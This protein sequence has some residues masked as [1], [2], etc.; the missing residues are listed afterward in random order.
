M[1]QEPPIENL[2]EAI[3]RSMI[4]HGDSRFFDENP[5]DSEH[6]AM[7]AAHP[8][9]GYLVSNAEEVIRVLAALAI[10]EGIIGESLK[11]GVVKKIPLAELLSEEVI[12]SLVDTI[13]TPDIRLSKTIQAVMELSISVQARS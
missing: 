11:Q 7:L 1:S 6:A 5:A 9:L 4:R 10:Y 2:V 3:Q 12:D 13:I 8:V